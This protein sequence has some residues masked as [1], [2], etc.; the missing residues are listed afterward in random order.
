METPLDRLV[1]LPAQIRFGEAKRDI[2]P[3][4]C[5]G[6]RWLFACRGGCLKHRF[7]RTADGE[8]GLNYLCPGLKAFF[9]HVDVPMRA[10]ADLVGSGRP[11]SEIMATL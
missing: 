7:G 11:A 6:C 1:D 2:L 9:E 8:V 4:E 5:R 10:M 3:R